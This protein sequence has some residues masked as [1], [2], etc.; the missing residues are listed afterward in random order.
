MTQHVWILLK[1]RLALEDH[2]ILIELRVHRVDLPLT[3]GIIE[4]V[5]D[6]GRC[7]AQ[8]RRGYAIDD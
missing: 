1:L 5:V 3:E 8:A 6:G 2:M 4:C 7:N